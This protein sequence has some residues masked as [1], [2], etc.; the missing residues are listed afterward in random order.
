MMEP[1]TMGLFIAITAAFGG[2]IAWARVKKVTVPRPLTWAEAPIVVAGA[3]INPAAVK[4]A[5]DWW[6]ARGHKIAIGHYGSRPT[7]AITIEV[8]KTLDERASFDDP[9]SCIKLGV[10]TVTA[11]GTKIKEARIRLLY[12]GDA[13]SLAHEIGHALGYGPGP[14]VK[15]HHPFGIPS[16]HMMHPSRAG[17]KDWR[18]L[19]V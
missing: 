6:L 10:T 13:L 8:D 11:D 5:V 2:L 17:W 12:G 1:V 19:E 18:G 14:G 9:D 4:E 7:G 15:L 16:G 3:G